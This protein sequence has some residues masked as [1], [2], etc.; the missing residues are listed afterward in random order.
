MEKRKQYYLRIAGELHEVE[1]E[2]HTAVVSGRWC[3][4]QWPQ[5]GLVATPDI[6]Y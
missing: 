2:V 5:C 3:G 4:D 1:R 6:A